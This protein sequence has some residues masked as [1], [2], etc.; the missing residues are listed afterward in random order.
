MAVI[1]SNGTGGG[2]FSAGA[3]WAGGVKPGAAD[4]FT[5]LS[6]DVIDCD[7]TEAVLSAVGNISTINSGGELQIT[8]TA[9]DLSVGRLDISGTFTAPGSGDKSLPS[10]LRVAHFNALANCLQ[11]FKSSSTMRTFHITDKTFLLNKMLLIKSRQIKY[12]YFISLKV[13]G[14]R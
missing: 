9:C 14:Y 4:T 3:S 13:K 1:N 11:V 8:G 10:I 5:I 12:F 2:K 7:T 6:G